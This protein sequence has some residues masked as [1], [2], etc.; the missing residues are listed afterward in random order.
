MLSRDLTW[1]EVSPAIKKLKNG[2]AAGWDNLV[3]EVLKNECCIKK[4]L[5]HLYEVCLKFCVTPSEW[6]R[7]IIHPI[8]KSVSKDLRCPE[9]QH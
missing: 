1:G 6:R 4:F 8:P 2:K 5:F 7:G 9:R 3:A